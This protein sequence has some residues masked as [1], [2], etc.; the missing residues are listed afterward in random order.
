MPFWPRRRRTAG[1]T[2][3][4]ALWAE[5]TSRWL[6]MRGL[7]E[8]ERERLR[9]LAVGFIGSKRFSG[10]HGLEVDDL[11]QVEIAAQ[12]CILVLELG[13]DWYDGWTEVIVY[14]A[15]FAPER[16]YVDDAGVVHT[17]H[18]PMAGEAWLGGPV[19]LSYEDVALAGDEELRVAGY[20]VVIHEFAHKLDMRNGDPNG[21]PPLHAGM[22]AREWKRDFSAAYEDFRAKVDA[23]ER[24]SSERRIQAAL[25]KLPIDPYAAESAAEF[26]AVGSEA[27]FETPERLAPAYPAIHARLRDFYR[28]DP[29]ARLGK[30]R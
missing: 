21:F 15:Q 10:T 8:P 28:Q 2:I 7:G 30:A 22:D 17:T 19:I 29:L 26:F 24:L 5:A 6:F 13:I 16:E 20:N 14:P 12:A 4:D 23:A 27:F 11:M 18:D 9:G 25:D 3:G 1:I